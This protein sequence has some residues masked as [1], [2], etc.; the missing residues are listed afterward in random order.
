MSAFWELLAEVPY[1]E[2]TVAALIK[3]AKVSPNTLYNHFNGY[4]DVV[5]SALNET[6]DPAL[7]PILVSGIAAEEEESPSLSHER[8]NK[9]ILFASDGSGE[10]TAMLKEALMQ[11]WLKSF[12][13]SDSDLDPIEEAELDF[14]FSGVVST[15]SRR[16]ATR[17]AD[18]REFIRSF[19]QRPLGRGVLATIETLGSPG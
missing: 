13:L 14:I 9:V 10:L 3:R 1:G 12:A 17:L 18:N 15:L 11:T 6:L 8:L 19:F 5:R 16:S 2:I 7:L 4:K